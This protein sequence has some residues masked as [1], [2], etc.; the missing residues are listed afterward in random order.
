MKRTASAA[1]SGLA[2]QASRSIEYHYD[3]ARRL[4]AATTT[5]EPEPEPEFSED[6]FHWLIA[7]AEIEHEEGPS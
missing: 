5:T 7:L 2:T 6:D 3:D 1:P 4:V